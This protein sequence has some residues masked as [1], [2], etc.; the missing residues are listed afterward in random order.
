LPAAV[1]F[2]GHS[3]SHAADWL[4]VRLYDLFS[5]AINE[6]IVGEGAADD[7]CEVDG[8]NLYA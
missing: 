2:D 1:L 7:A 4:N 5:E 8:K 6:E 3:G